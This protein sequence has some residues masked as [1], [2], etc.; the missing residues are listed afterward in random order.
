MRITVATC[1]AFAILC[2]LLITRSPEA[3]A[4]DFQAKFIEKV[5]EKFDKDGNGQLDAAEMRAAMEY[6]R[7]MQAEKEKGDAKGEDDEEPESKPKPTEAELLEMYDINRNGRL[8]P[9]ER[10]L[11]EQDQKKK[12]EAAAREKLDGKD[13]E[14]VGEESWQ[15]YE[16]RL[17]AKYD[18]NGNKKLDTA[19]R[20]EAESEIS[21]WRLNQRKIKA[22]KDAAMRHLTLDQRRL[23]AMFDDNNNYKLDDDER[24]YASEQFKK[25]RKAG[26][27]EALVELH[28]RFLKQFDRNKNGKLDGKE[29]PA[30]TQ[31]V[32][33]VAAQL[34]AANKADQRKNWS[35]NLRG[36]KRGKK[37]RAEEKQKI[38]AKRLFGG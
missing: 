21:K 24:E 19:E 35:K 37:A 29:K 38:D 17:I 5:M 8:D 22:Q 12:D 25:L 32:I 7:R 20:R 34:R 26:N 36:Y 30:A 4:Q 28:G 23:V 13:L 15:D 2:A 16:K 11:A 14:S 9:E 10:L 1:I 27:L 3:V 31:F 6:R 18:V 33:K